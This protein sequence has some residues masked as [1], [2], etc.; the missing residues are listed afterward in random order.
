MANIGDRVLAVWPQ[1]QGEW[2]YPGVVVSDAGGAK[3]VVFDDGGRAAISDAE[4][5]P[6]S[7]GAGKRVFC[8][9]KGGDKYYGGVVSSATGGCI[10]INYDD[11]D[12]EST[13]VSLVRINRA[14]VQ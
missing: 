5:I 2:W 1:E 3:E 12:K 14:D 9:W 13:S 8:R 11:G 7:I 4:M 6:L 10:H